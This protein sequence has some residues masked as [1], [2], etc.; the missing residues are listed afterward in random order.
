MHMKMKGWVD[1]SKAGHNG[2]LGLYVVP[3]LL[4]LPVWAVSTHLNRITLVSTHVQA[5]ICTR[6]SSRSQL[7]V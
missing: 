6:A 7:P 5:Y 4:A 1:K 3:P 2:K